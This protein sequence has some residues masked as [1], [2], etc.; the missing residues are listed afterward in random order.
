MPVWDASITDS[1]FICSAMIVALRFWGWLCTGLWFYRGKGQTSM[2]SE[3]FLDPKPSKIL[4]ED[5]MQIGES[6]RVHCGVVG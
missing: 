6:R 2:F 5:Q 1:G 3:H 4:I